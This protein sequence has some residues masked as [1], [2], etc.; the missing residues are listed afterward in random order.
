MG[1][2]V[3]RRVWS[4][5]LGNDEIR[6]VSKVRRHLSHRRGERDEMHDC[7]MLRWFSLFVKSME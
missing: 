4:W 2:R 7:L 3:V 1:R 6:K 5:W